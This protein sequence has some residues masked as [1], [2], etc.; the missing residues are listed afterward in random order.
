M[1]GIGFSELSYLSSY[2]F[3]FGIKKINYIFDYE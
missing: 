2:Q 1:L 3:H